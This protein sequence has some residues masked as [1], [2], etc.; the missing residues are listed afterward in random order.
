MWDAVMHQRTN[1]QL[2][3]FMPQ[4]IQLSDLLNLMRIGDGAM[5]MKGL[6]DINI[7]SKE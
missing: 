6:Y 5:L 3:I 1:M 4:N 2:D 7:E